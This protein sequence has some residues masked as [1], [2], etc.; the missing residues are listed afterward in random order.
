MSELASLL[1]A[2]L[3]A[4]PPASPAR[5]V[6]EQAA[7]DVAAE[8]QRGVEAYNAQ[9]I[10]YYES[11]LLPEAVFVA[12]DGAVFAGKERVLR[13]FSRVFT[14]TPRRQITVSDVATEV[15]GDV[16]WTRFKWTL[17]AGEASRAGVATTVFLRGPADRWQV[18]LI[19]NTR[20]GHGAPA[21]TKAPHRH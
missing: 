2:A 15:R 21:S 4:A 12:D 3:L 18:A 16:A 11:A 6:P 13:Q 19:Q 20:A 5:A 9:Q 7:S 8:V 10:A 17:S 14:M 1:L